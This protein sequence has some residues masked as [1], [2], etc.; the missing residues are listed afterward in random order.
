VVAA[1]G[2]G[3]GAAAA[4]AAWL[5]A[6]PAARDPF[7]LAVS[8][9]VA[10]GFPGR[11]PVGSTVL[12]A[13]TVAADLG[14]DTPDGFQSLS[15]LHLGQSTLDVELSYLDTLRSALPAA[16]VG[17][18]LTVST[19]T[20]TAERGA[21]LV[22]RWPGAVAE[23]MEGYGVAC[24]ARLAGAAFVELRTV[25]NPV[26]P[27]DRAAWRLDEALAALERSVAALASLDG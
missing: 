4:T 19:V 6:V 10:G 26:G 22:Q 11:A 23:A 17:D 24:A 13:R 12:A 5:L 9:G 25:S 1:A 20:G 7:D 8:A 16:V 21:A 15:D 3:P 14:A 27:R 2:V 18:V